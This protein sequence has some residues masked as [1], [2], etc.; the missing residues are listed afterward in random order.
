M[1][2]RFH[3]LAKRHVVD[4][5]VEKEKPRE[6]TDLLGGKYDVAKLHLSNSR[7]EKPL[8]LLAYPPPSPSSSSSSSASAISL[9]TQNQ[10]EEAQQQ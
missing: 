5:G 4:R 10:Q 7:Q 3:H 8:I 9:N 6:A 2:R 1:I